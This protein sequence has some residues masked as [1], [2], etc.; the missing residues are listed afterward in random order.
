MDAAIGKIE[1]TNR[2]SGNS[3]QEDSPSTPGGFSQRDRRNLQNA[4]NAF[5]FT[6]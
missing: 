4:D 5:N 6:S 3:N 2:R 1:V